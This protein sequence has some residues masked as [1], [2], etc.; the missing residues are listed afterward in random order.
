MQLVFRIL[1]DLKNQ[2]LFLKRLFVI[3]AGIH[4]TLNNIIIAN[5]EDLGQTASDLGLHCFSRPIWQ[6][7][8][9]NFRTLTIAY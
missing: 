8:F 6:T 3:R 4:K 1:E 5:R 2:F 7:S 9:Q